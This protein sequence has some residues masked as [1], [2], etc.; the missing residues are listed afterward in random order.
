MAESARQPS[1]REDRDRLLEAHPGPPAA[2]V[3]GLCREDIPPEELLSPEPGRGDLSM[4]ELDPDR[5]AIKYVNEINRHDLDALSALMTP[6]FWFIDSVGQE[7]RGRERMV[8]AWKAYFARFPDY[9]I[10]LRDHL[11]LGS[12]VALFGTASG[13]LA[14]NG[15]LPHANRWS[16]PA[17]WRAVVRGG[18]L[19]EWQV[20]ADHEPVRK[21]LAARPP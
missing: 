16:L 8:D 12:V 9:R 2:D 20:Y 3:S 5:L 15:E 21:L 18:H 1:K 10:V 4:P 7:V 17:A 14:V 13:T 19:A 11:T 6:D